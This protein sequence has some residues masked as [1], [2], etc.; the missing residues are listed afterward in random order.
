MALRRDLLKSMVGAACANFMPRKS[1]AWP[2]LGEQ[3]ESTVNSKERLRW[4]EDARFGLFLHWGI[5]SVTAGE[6]NGRPVPSPE[7][8][9]LVERIPLQQYG[10]LARELTLD[11]YNP[12]RWVEL[13]K[14]AGMKYIVITAKHHEGF[15]MFDSPSSAYNIV[16]MS[17][18]GKDPMKPLAAA[19]ARHGIRLCFYYSLGRDWQDPDVPTNW[20]TKAA[21]SNTWDYP[22]EDSKVF[23][24]YFQRKVKP[25]IR[26][27]LT[28]YGPVGVIWF[29]TPE[30][31]SRKESVELREL[32]NQ[33]QPDCL[34]NDR[35]GNGQGDFVISEQRLVGNASRKPWEACMTMGRNWGYCKSDRT[36]KSPEVLVR[37]LIEVVS[38]GGNLLLDT[39]PT[40]QGEFTPEATARLQSIGAWMD[41]NGEAIYGTQAWLAADEQEQEQIEENNPPAA[42][43]NSKNGDAMKDAVNDA[44]SRTVSADLR[45]TAKADS[46]YMFARSWRDSAIRTQ[47]FNRQRLVVRSV[48]LLGSKE[49]IRWEQDKSNLTVWMPLALRAD[50]PVY[51][52][53]VRL[54]QDPVRQS[55]AMGQ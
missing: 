32:V 37:D 1:W 52:F 10:K 20:P 31:I 44:T 19:C 15:A 46:V 49:T 47:A 27:L 40:A 51:T 5:Y 53:R 6:W 45:F 43:S 9:M 55:S 22:D 35:I 34:V 25:Q 17:P 42:P 3:Q 7:F 50:I 29:D 33:L 38:K 21:R 54:G 14:E 30:L 41:V 2:G 48:D 12:E 16:R 4:W 8:V 28:Q 26:E 18:Y 13:A 36:Y 11:N 39:G 24:R 23:S